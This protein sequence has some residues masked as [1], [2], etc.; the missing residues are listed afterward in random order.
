MREFITGSA[1]AFTITVAIL[2]TWNLTAYR[3]VDYLKE[4]APEYVEKCGFTITAYEGYLGDPFS[5]GGVWY[6]AKDT[7]GYLYQFE[8]IE[9]RGELHLYSLEC[10]NAVTNK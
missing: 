4:A 6:Q 9:W 8:I 5:G 3:D 1:V 10:L 7:R 2:L